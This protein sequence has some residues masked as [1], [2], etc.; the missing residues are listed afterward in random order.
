MEY[1]DSTRN[2]RFQTDGD[3][4]MVEPALEERWC[5]RVRK[6]DNCPFHTQFVVSD[7]GKRS[8]LVF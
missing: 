8:L 1:T 4:G 7:L 6:G 5:R 2:P 3:G